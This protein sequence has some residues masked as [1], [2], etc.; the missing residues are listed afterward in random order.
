MTNNEKRMEQMKNLQKGDFIYKSDIVLLESMEDSE[1]SS[2]EHDSLFKVYTERLEELFPEPNGADMM[3][4]KRTCWTKHSKEDSVKKKQTIREQLQLQINGGDMHDAGGKL[5][6][7]TLW[8]LVCYQNRELELESKY[9]LDDEYDGNG[10]LGA[11]VVL[12]SANMA[13][14][15][16]KTAHLRR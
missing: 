16:K 1:V 12:T 14:Y 13:M 8:K 11:A 4:I 3:M 9:N 2:V 6:P 5:S 15:S 7:E 10:D